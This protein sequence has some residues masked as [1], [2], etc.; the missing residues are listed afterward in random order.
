MNAV[1]IIE[2]MQKL[3]PQEFAKVIEFARHVPNQ[4]TIDALNE[5]KEGLPRYKTMD[6]VKA[7]IKEAVQES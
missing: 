2:E 7:A 1:Q 5:N 6:E 3:P 4:E